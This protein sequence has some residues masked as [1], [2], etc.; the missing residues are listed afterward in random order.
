MEL[1]WESW[2]RQPLNGPRLLELFRDWGFHSFATQVQ[3]VTK[4][5]APVA[6]R[7]ASAPEVVREFHADGSLFAAETVTAEAVAT[8]TVEPGPTAPPSVPPLTR[9]ASDVTYRLVDNPTLFQTFLR[10]LRAQSRFA[11]DLETTGLEP[12]RSAIVGLSFCWR[13]GEAWYLPVRAPQGCAVLDHEQT[14]SQLRPV[15]EDAGVQKV[16][17]NIK[18]DMLVLRQHG[19]QMRGV[20]GDPMVADYLLNPGERSRNKETLARAYLNLEVIPIEQLIGKRGS[21]QKCMD[22]IP[23]DL[24][25]QYAGQDSDIALQLCHCTEARLAEEGLKTPLYDQLEIPL[26]DVLAELEFNGIRL[27]VP[28]LRSLGERLGNEIA[29]FEQTIY[30]LAGE[31]FAIASLRQ[32]RRILFEK[33]QLK[34]SRKTDI[35]GEPSTDQRTLEDLAARGEELPR[36][37]LEYRRLTKLKSTYI[38]TLPQLVNPDT[39]RVHC[40][41]QQTVAATGRLSSADPNLQNIPIRTEL[42]GQI[43]QAFIPEPG[44]VLLSADYS[45]IELRLLAHFSGDQE[46]R[47]AFQ[48]DHDIHALVAAQIYGVA[49]AD[50]TS[51][52]R[53]MAKTVNFGVIYGMSAHGL[54]QRLQIP[55]E[56]AATF[57]QR[58]FARYPNVLAY[59]QQLLHACRE[60]GFVS[61]ILGR[62][63]FFQ[64]EAIRAASTYQQ[65]NTAEREAIN[66]EIQG[67]AADLIKEAMLKIHH[68]LKA[69]MR[70]TRMLLQIHDELV[71]ESPP[72]EVGE[73]AR[74]VEREMSGALG[75]KLTV[76]LKVDVSAGPNW[77]DVKPLIL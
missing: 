77:L 20:A 43:R 25:V 19:I 68:R 55:R 54:A 21:A 13:E 11:L 59:Q 22:Q 36:Q 30:Q 8:A 64:K 27:D 45:Q 73:V 6:A 17:Q 5:T 18:Y 31:E 37:I 50:V 71:F 7:R 41:F 39:G 47:R 63:R 69:E 42:G 57:I 24:V 35:T 60:R 12:R 52:M 48:D 58:Y 74:L 44:W 26:I 65:R 62:R 2:R 75:S 76:S 34:P 32:L 33:L 1:D 38:D 16:N 28:L 15:L 4:T 10:D 46:M 14:I 61:T 66:M 23:T 40:S 51:E 29:R 70:R 49:E 3:A 9:R 67:S 56:E 72:E 53:R